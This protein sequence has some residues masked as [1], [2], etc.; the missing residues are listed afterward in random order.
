MSSSNF[1]IAK[2]QINWS[3]TPEI[4]FNKQVINGLRMAEYTSVDADFNML[5][6]YDTGNNPILENEK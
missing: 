4:T 5:I 3:E 6:S 1:S 2:D